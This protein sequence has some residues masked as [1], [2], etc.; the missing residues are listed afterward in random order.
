MKTQRT[1]HTEQDIERL[2]RNLDRY[3]SARKVADAI[4]ARAEVWAK[5]DDRFLHDLPPPADIFRAFHPSF[6]GCPIHGEA[7][8]RVPGGA[9]KIDP[10]E[11]PWKVR[12]AIGGEEYPSNDFAAYH[13]TKDPTLLTGDHPDDGLGWDPKDGRKKFWFAAHYCFQLYHQIMDALRDLSRAYLITGDPRFGRKGAILLN[14]LAERFPTMDHAAQSW[15]GLE[16]LKNYTGRFLY[17]VTESFHI[18]L[19]AEAYENLLPAL[20]SDPEVH[21]FTGRGPEAL[22]AHVEENLVR[23]SIRDIWEGKIRG[24]YGLHQASAVRALVALDDPKFTAWALDN[25]RNYTGVGPETAVWA[26]GV[27]GWGHALDN[28]LFRDGVSFEVA[29]GYSVGCWT[30]YLLD[31][32][33]TLRRLGDRL[34]EEYIRPLGSWP[35]RLACHNGAMPAIADTGYATTYPPLDASALQ[36]FLRGYAWPEYARALL[37]RGVFGDACF[38]DFEDLFEEPLAKEDLERRAGDLSSWPEKSDNLGGV[39]F[40]V[41]RSGRGENQL[42]AVLQYGHANAGH[43][44]HDRLNLEVLAGGVKVVPDTGYPTHAAEH[45]DP[46]AWEKNTVSH[47]TVVVNERRQDTADAGT[48]V[49]F[50][51]TPRL[52]HIEVSSD[53]AYRDAQVYRR[54]VT[55]LDL[56]PDLQVLV[57]LFRVRGGWAHDYSLHGFDAP[58]SLAGLNLR[59]QE[60]GTLAGPEVPFR[61]LY[62]DPELEA[63]AKLPGPPGT[64]GKRS[65]STY[66]GSGF[67]Y[68]TRVSRGEQTGPFSAD[69]NDGR[70][71]LRVSIPAGVAQ[72]VITADGAPPNKP[73]NPERLKY[74]LLRNRGDR[75]KQDL[76]SLF[77]LVCE[78]YRGSPKI[79]DIERLDAD[80]EGAI[81]LRI[82]WPGGTCYLASALDEDTPCAFSGGLTLQ[83]GLGALSL[84]SHGRPVWAALS[85]QSLRLGEV[86]VTG[87]GVWAGTIAEVDYAARRVTV[88][89]D[90]GARGGPAPGET[91]LVSNDEHACNLPIRSMAEQK[92]RY[93]LDLDAE[94]LSIGRFIVESETENE[95]LTRTWIHR[96]W[97]DEH[98]GCHYLKGA[99]LAYKGRL[100]RIAQPHARPGVGGHRLTLRDP[101][102][103]ADAT[104]DRAVIYDLGPGDRCCVRPTLFRTF[105]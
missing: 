104:G 63:H 82:A 19:Y 13:L 49:R 64:N 32:D 20:L 24:N 39:G 94:R 95:L 57:D 4:L 11:R 2:K 67:S 74:L 17:A 50:A 35:R 16:Y 1:L 101:I 72:E 62:D 103:F 83:G 40:A 38:T 21:A 93:V 98:A 6:D 100:W 79:L 91:L 56:A 8:F 14:R 80:R 73:G 65:F 44:H 43:A 5:Q 46:P 99:R 92:G 18:A 76:H 84:D 22:V 12:C 10:F 59:P 105:Q 53:R 45:P 85:G 88:A 25:L 41:L 68:L 52:Q 36:R 27:E 30:R 102:P 89:P 51:G 87:P 7:V 23:Q 9:W 34:P 26:Y 15:Y 90:P 42:A 86:E 29:V 31:T 66:R 37:D 71:G 48:L 47:V 28:F 33:L 69:W 70:I 60:G 58:F 81:A 54:A 55:L 96:E 77:A 61:K 3:P 97:P 78:A 75:Q